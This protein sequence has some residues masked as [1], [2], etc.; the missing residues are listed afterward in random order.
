MSKGPKD[1]IKL[2]FEVLFL[3]IT[4]YGLLCT[5][6]ADV[7]IQ[8]DNEFF[9]LSRLTIPKKD[10]E[11]DFGKIIGGMIEKDESQ[12]AQEGNLYILVFDISGS[13]QNERID[14]NVSQNYRERIEK[15][16]TLFNESLNFDEDI[17]ILNLSKLRLY[18]ILSEFYKYHD[19]YKNDK[20][21]IWTLGDKGKRLYPALIFDEKINQKTVFDAMNKLSKFRLIRPDDNTD[22]Y[23]L[24]YKIILTNEDKIK[25][26][27]KDTNFSPKII[28]TFISDLLHDVDNKELFKSKEKKIIEDWEK[29][30]KKIEQICNSGIMVNLI[31]LKNIDKENRKSVFPSFYKHLDWHRLNYPSLYDNEN[32]DLLFPNRYVEGNIKFCYTTPESVADISLCLKFPF[33]EEHECQISII[34]EDNIPIIPRLSFHCKIP[35]TKDETIIFSDGGFFRPKIPESGMIK[36]RLRNR[37]LQSVSIPIL[38]VSDFKSRVSYLIPIYFKKKLPE[39]VATFFRV[40]LVSIILCCL[41]IPFIILNFS[42]SKISRR[43]SFLFLIGSIVFLII[44]IYF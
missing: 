28:L 3:S 30:E 7:I 25:P 37:T 14:K 21:S 35:G 10:L 22:Y 32:A 19:K 12:T 29:L 8:N 9:R 27:I 2:L 1:L 13:F 43:L 38:K 23:D 15:I 39:K 5:V 16:R 20:F 40:F 36:L 44:Y 24:L 42:P 31:I 41:F 26:I 6:Y 4:V 11:N 18:E 17:N 34:G 33:N